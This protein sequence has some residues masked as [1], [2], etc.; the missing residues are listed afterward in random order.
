MCIS[1]PQGKDMV[2]FCHAAPFPETRCDG[3]LMLLGGPEL[4]LEGPGPSSSS[5]PP[6][7]GVG[8]TQT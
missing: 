8:P 3:R 4:T 7:W 2:L 5:P 6:P 1:A